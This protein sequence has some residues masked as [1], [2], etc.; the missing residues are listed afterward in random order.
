MGCVISEQHCVDSE[1]D[2]ATSEQLSRDFRA[3]FE[4]LLNNFDSERTLTNDFQC[5]TASSKAGSLR[6]C[7]RISYRM[8]AGLDREYVCTNIFRGLQSES[9]H[10]D[11]QSCPLAPEVHGKV[12]IGKLFK[13]VFQQ[14]IKFC[15]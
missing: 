5:C 1:R 14:T 15:Q 9:A 12:N 6:A 7:P 8:R 13:R 2:I 4:Q 11:R 3:T 10:G